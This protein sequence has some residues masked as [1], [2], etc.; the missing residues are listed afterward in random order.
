M[1]WNDRPDYRLGELNNVLVLSMIVFIQIKLFRLPLIAQRVLH[2]PIMIARS[3]LFIVIVWSKK[4]SDL[5][6]TAYQS[7]LV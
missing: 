1:I 5:A 4:I 2:G 7:F 6:W 3:F